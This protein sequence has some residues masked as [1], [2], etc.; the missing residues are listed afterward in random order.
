MKAVKDNLS[1]HV[2]Y[3]DLYI[4]SLS[5]GEVGTL[6]AAAFNIPHNFQV[7]TLGCVDLEAVT[8]RLVDARV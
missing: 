7:L 2:A 4:N 1:C 3:V 8:C 6:P 5:V